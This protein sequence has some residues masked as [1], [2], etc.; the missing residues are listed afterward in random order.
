MLITIHFL[1]V[2][3]IIVLVLLQKSGEDGS[4]FSKVN[5]NK[6]DKIDSNIIKI[7]VFFICLFILNSIAMLYIKN[8]QHVAKFQAIQKE[9]NKNFN[10]NI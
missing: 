6:V 7:T 1:T 10:Q 8:S 5:Q 9:N 2:I 4:L 3:M